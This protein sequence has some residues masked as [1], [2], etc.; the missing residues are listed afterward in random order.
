M[1]HLNRG[2]WGVSLPPKVFLES[3]RIDME[4]NMDLIKYYKEQSDEE[5]KKLLRLGPDSFEQEAYDII[6]NEA[7]RRGLYNDASDIKGIEKPLGEMTRVEIL[8]LLMSAQTMEKDLY[9]ALCAEAF[10][11]N[12]C[13]DEIEH[14]HREILKAQKKENNEE[15]AEVDSR[16]GNFLPLI[17]LENLEDARP[18]FETL[19]EADI[20][21]S[22]QIMVEEKN[23]DQADSIISQLRPGEDMGD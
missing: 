21:Y 3:N 7:N 2:S 12:I 19:T 22:I 13:R 18:Y 1:L 9:D 8:G 5:I 20:P 6:R 14:L 11:R 17:I 15:D 10:R 4:N 16:P 23:Y